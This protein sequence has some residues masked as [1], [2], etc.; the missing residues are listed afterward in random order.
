MTSATLS[1]TTFTL[2]LYHQRPPLYRPRQ[3]LYCRWL[4]PYPRLP[5]TLAHSVRGLQILCNP[6]PSLLMSQF[7]QPLQRIFDICPSDQL[8]R[9]FF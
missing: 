2:S 6:H 9:V 5:H 8:L 7:V 4:P 3:P 1:S